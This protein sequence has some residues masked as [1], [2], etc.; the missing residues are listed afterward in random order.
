MVL[1]RRCDI[2]LGFARHLLPK[3]SAPA[4][5]LNETTI[6]PDSELAHA[7]RSV[8]I[9]KLCLMRKKDRVR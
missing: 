5:A 8:L 2:V 3:P 6:Y 4:L 9:R 7:L 1:Q